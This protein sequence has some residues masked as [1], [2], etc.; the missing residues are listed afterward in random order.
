MA[1][2]RTRLSLRV[3]AVAGLVLAAKVDAQTP[4]LFSDALP[5]NPS[6]STPPTVASAATPPESGPDDVFS[7]RQ[8]SRTVRIALDLL[9]AARAEVEL[10]AATRLSLNLFDDEALSAIVERTAPTQS[11]YSL[12]GRIEGVPFGTFALVVNGDVV[13]GSVHTPG[14]RYSIRT[15]GKATYR[16]QRVDP[17][18]EPSLGDDTVQP[19]EPLRPSS[20]PSAVPSDGD[21][22]AQADDG[23]VIDVF[24]FWTRASRLLVGGLRPIR[25]MIDL[26]VLETNEAY[27]AGGV[28]QRINLVGAS[29]V[30]YDEKGLFDDIA[31]LQ[32][33]TDGDMDEIHQVRDSYAA[34]LVHLVTSDARL[35]GPCG[36]IAYVTGGVAGVGVACPRRDGPA[37]LR[38]Q[39]GAG[40]RA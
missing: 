2:G 33:R 10:G 13:A 23:S 27:E 24:V 15:V 22:E 20:A 18:S 19:P 26:A 34:D 11:G 32:D 21:P 3:L 8:R 25:A 35:F 29:E 5:S 7:A 40:V 30:K 37:E 28:I 6:S 14:A 39:R 17:A 12:S 38:C 36:G 1:L 31:H 4:D 9:A 16:V